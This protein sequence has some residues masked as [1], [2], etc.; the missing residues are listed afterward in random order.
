MMA[1]FA[2]VR[3]Y[4]PL[5]DMTISAIGRAVVIH[6]PFRTR[7]KGDILPHEHINYPPFSTN[8]AH[9]AERIGDL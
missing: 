3:F 1:R 2:E 8:A 4:W 6:R 7:Q 9:Q 5:K